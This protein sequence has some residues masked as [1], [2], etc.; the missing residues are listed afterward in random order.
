MLHHWLRLALLALCAIPIA[1]AQQSTGTI[2]G[3]VTDQQGA[4]IPGAQVEVLNTQTNA[5]FST[6]SNENG[7]YVAPGLAVGEY[8]ISVESDG[9]RRSVR[10]GVTLQV[11]QNADINVTLEI[12]Q[13]TEVVEV[14]GEAPLV[15]TGGA[16][17]GEVIERK[18]VSDLPI[19]GRG[20]LALTMLT[21]GVISNAGPTN[22][23]FG[24]RGIQL[25]SVSINGSPNSMNAQML[26]GNN[27]ILSYVGEVGVPIAVDSVQE[28]KVQSGTM[29]SEFGYTAGGAINLVTRSGTNSLHGTAYE[30]LRND[31]LD[32]RNAFARSRLPLRYNQYGA[33]VGGP[34]I[35]NRTF[36]FFNWE[37]YRLARSSPRIRTVPIPE[38]LEGKFGNLR[39]A[40]GVL[41]PLEHHAAESG[42][43]G[44]GARSVRQ[45]QSPC[46]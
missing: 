14:V 46:L 35:K 29:S 17:L 10:S 23:G 42:R 41:I 26:D 31:V 18:R 37:E 21:A 22:S 12:G 6:S 27:N 4:V 32:A 3:I 2:A 39:N 1:L 9:F 45:Q 8:E 20:A 43:R 34:L 5:L 30:F 24:D 33:S 28:F 7:L 38:F 15:D 44:L 40:N 16:T 36:G 11:G 25:S 13:V 19:N